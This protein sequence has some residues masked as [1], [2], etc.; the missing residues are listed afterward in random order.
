MQRRIRGFAAAVLAIIAGM[1]VILALAYSGKEEE[2][3][4]ILN[5]SV[6]ITEEQYLALRR[7][8]ARIGKDTKVWT[9]DDEINYTA[10][11]A[12][13]LMANEELQKEKIAIRNAEITDDFIV[14]DTPIRVVAVQKEPGITTQTL[15]DDPDGEPAANNTHTKMQDEASDCSCSPETD[16]FLHCVHAE[17][18][19]QSLE[20]K[21]ATAEVIRNRVADPR[22]PNTITEVIMQPGQFSVV[23]N[24]QIGKVWPDEDTIKAVEACMAGSRTI[25]EDYIYFNN[26]PIGKDVIQIGGHYFGR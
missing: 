14:D 24:G 16:L 20:C 4:R 9:V 8:A 6:E 26:A 12:L 10:S 7:R 23:S 19:N 5:V 2:D 1:S 18:G 25:P 17:A 21:T 13:A 15:S 22:F 3:M 11:A